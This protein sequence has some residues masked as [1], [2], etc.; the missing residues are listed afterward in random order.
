VADAR[1]Q[2]GEIVNP[3]GGLPNRSLRQHAIGPKRILKLILEKFN[4]DNQ[5]ISSILITTDGC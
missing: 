3:G 1:Q 4:F 2:G 5:I